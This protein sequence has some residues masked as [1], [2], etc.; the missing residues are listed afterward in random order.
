[1]YKSK[2]IAETVNAIKINKL[3]NRISALERSY[4]EF[5]KPK[6]GPNFIVCNMSKPEGQRSEKVTGIGLLGDNF[7]VI[8]IN[9][10]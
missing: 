1:M 3:E 2:E 9:G 10:D 6:S 5:R 8:E 4:A 7:A